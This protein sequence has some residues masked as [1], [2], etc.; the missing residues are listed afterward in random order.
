MWHTLGCLIGAAVV[1]WPLFALY[2]DVAATPNIL[3]IGSGL[4]SIIL[5]PEVVGLTEMVGFSSTALAQI[6]ATVL[7]T[8]KILSAS[9]WA[10]RRQSESRF[11][12]VL[13]M[14]VES[15]D[16]SFPQY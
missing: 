15:G 9:S 16:G 8:R 4:G 3:F 6:I 12:G 14:I 2:P 7:I 5:V 1:D 10:L 13:W 11:M